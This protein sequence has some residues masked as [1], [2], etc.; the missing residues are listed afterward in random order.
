MA[1]Q[2]VEALRSRSALGSW[3]RVKA[4]H[5]HTLKTPTV[6]PAADVRERPVEALVDPA[7]VLRH[8]ALQPC[9]ECAIAPAAARTHAR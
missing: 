6:R 1:L 5:H 3:Q 8:G 9:P 4:A 7:R 2:H